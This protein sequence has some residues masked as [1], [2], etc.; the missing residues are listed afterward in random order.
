MDQFRIW[1]SEQSSNALVLLIDEYDTPL[2]SNL[3]NKE[4]FI[5][6][7]NRLNEFYAAIKEFELCFRFFF[8]TGITKLSS[9]SI[10]SAFNNLQDI[11]QDPLYGN[12][13]GYT[14]KEI[15]RYFLRHI[16]RAGDA[17]G[18]SRDDVLQG[19]KTYYDGFCF[20]EKGAHHVYCPWSVL[21]FLNRPDRGWQNYWYASGGQPLVLQ[22]YLVNNPLSDPMAYAQ[23]SIVRLSELNA[24]RDYEDMRPEILLTQASYLTIQSID[25]EQYAV[26]GYPN[27]EVSLSMAEL[28]ANQLLRNK[29]IETENRVPLLSA[30]QSGDA[31]EVMAFFNSAA[32]AIDYLRYPIRD[33]TSCRAYMQVL[34]IGAA[35]V[36]HVE[37]HN[38]HGRSDL[39]VETKTYRWIFEFKYARDSAETPKLLEAAIEQI[40][41]NHYGVRTDE[42]KLIRIALVFDAQS[43]SF[44]AWKRC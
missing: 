8:M 7:R 29:R 14:E 2:T 15:R 19:L 27:R 34:L 30:M 39:E 36:P 41:R 9:T 4:A 35:L 10:F 43:R 32:Y 26:L 22:K 18:C 44:A 42:K 17:L 16:D 20:D 40:H 23:P 12:L 5:F 6:I 25:G 1:L 13:L 31:A 37:V 11:S 24:A 33:E 3:D 21:S 28:Y 38:A